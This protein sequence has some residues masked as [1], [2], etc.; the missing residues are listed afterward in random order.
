MRIVIKSIVNAVP[1]IGNMMIV[2]V[3]VQC[4]FAILGTNLYKGTFYFC[5]TKNIKTKS[6][7]IE[8]KF[9]CMD[10]G[11][12]WV[13]RDQNFDNFW[14]SMLTFTNIMTTEG[15][16]EVMWAGVDSTKIDMVSKEGNNP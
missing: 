4:L 15:W 12:E 6:V 14:N 11:G 7:T 8:D 13:N 16:I 5:D 3:L 10:Y 9:D 2:S 1:D